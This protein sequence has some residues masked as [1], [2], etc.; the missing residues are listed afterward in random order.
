[1]CVDLAMLYAAYRLAYLI[2]YRVV[3]RA[4]IEVPPPEVYQDTL[5]LVAVSLIGVFAFFRHYIPR[6]GLSRIDLLYSLFLAVSATFVIALAANTLLYREFGLPRV[7]YAGWWACAIVLIWMARVVVDTMLRLGRAHGVDTAN[8]LIVGAGE[9]G[10]IIL[11]RSD[12]P[13]SLATG[14]SASSMTSTWTC[15]RPA[16]RSW[17][18]WPMCRASSSTITLAS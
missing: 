10:Q 5:L 17:A 1:M 15:I 16:R 18:P 2:R 8:V 11:R 13:Q 4:G 9:S 6:R 7:V 14:W 12:T 3:I